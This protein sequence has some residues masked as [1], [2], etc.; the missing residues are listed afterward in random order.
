MYNFKL[1][2]IRKYKR[3]N[4]IVSIL[5]DTFYECNCVVLIQ[6]NKSC[7]S[8]VWSQY[9]HRANLRF[10]VAEGLLKKELLQ[11]ACPVPVTFSL[12]NVG[13]L[14]QMSI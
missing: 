5:N 7:S 10:V 12:E 13:M 2:V 11:I 14:K 1:S 9:S 3:G 6:A 8:E 4:V